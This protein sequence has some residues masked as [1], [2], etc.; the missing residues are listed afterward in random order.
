M[1][2]GDVIDQPGEGE[3]FEILRSARHD[4]AP[5]Q[6]EW[7][8]Q[9]GKP[10]PPEHIHPHDDEIIKVLA[11]RARITLDGDVHLVEAGSSMRLPAGVPHQIRGDGDE[12][13]RCRV[14]SD[15]GHGFET[16]LDL[17]A[18]G[19]FRGFAKAAQYIDR[20]PE[21]LVQTQRHIRAVVWSIGKLGWL[22]GHRYREA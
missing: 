10:G 16:V 20:H 17:L 12:P 13:L 6:F 21:T 1:R 14:T 5:L 11:G 19:G 8:L 18:E 2:K 3:R 9:P 4:G 7:T 22:F 15:Q